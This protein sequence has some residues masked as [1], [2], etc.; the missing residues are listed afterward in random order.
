MHTCIDKEQNI[1]QVIYTC[2]LNGDNRA[3]ISSDAVAECEG[4]SSLS[5]P[6]SSAKLLVVQKIKKIKYIQV[7]SNNQM[8]LQFQRNHKNALQISTYTLDSIGLLRNASSV[9]YG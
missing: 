1:K 2:I 4:P 3:T 8:P 7:Q 6:S 5:S 9:A